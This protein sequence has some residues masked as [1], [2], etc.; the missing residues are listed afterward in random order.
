MLGVFHGLIT[1]FLIAMLKDLIFR[2]N[3]GGCAVNRA[4]DSWVGGVNSTSVLCRSNKC[5][6]SF[7]YLLARRTRVVSAL[8]EKIE[9]A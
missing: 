5:L 7:N 6:K 8:V 1:T 2:K 4:R 9:E 3:F